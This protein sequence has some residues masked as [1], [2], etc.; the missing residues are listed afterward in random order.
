MT[1]PRISGGGG[2]GGEE[3][4]V[5]MLWGTETVSDGAPTTEYRRQAVTG[6]GKFIPSLLLS[7]SLCSAGVAV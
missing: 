2:H 6:P 4:G 3:G 7:L 5:E 1:V